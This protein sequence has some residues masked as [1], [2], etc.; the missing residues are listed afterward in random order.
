MVPIITAFLVGAALYW[1]SLGA[2]LSRRDKV[3]GAGIALLNAMYLVLSVLGID[4]GLGDAGVA[5]QTEG[6]TP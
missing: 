4:V 2:D 6:P 5:D 1:M 3:L